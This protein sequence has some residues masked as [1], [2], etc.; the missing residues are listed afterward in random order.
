[1]PCLFCSDRTHTLRFCDS[2]IGKSIFEDV[3]LFILQNKYN[4][5]SQI[6]YFRAFTKPQL[7]FINREINEP[8]S[9][10]KYALIYNIIRHFFRIATQHSEFRNITQQDMN[11]IHS[12]YTDHHYQTTQVQSPVPP[13]IMF[14]I[15]IKSMID[16]FYGSRYGLRRH[17]MSLIRYFELL[18]EVADNEPFRLSFY[19]RE[20]RDQQEVA[21]I[22]D[23]VAN[24]DQGFIDRISEQGINM[25]AAMYQ[26]PN[27]H[28]QKLAFQIDTDA[29]LNEVKDCFLC[30]EEKSHAKLGCSHEYCIDCI[31]GIAKARTKSFISCAVCR[32]EVDLV[33]VGSEAIKA[34]LKQKINTV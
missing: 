34:D 6:I 4:I 8:I 19:E 9:S 15:N 24:L 31:F 1:M 5:A 2:E 22:E 7:A 14:S 25:I 33:Q 32:A 23:M 30:C 3:E 28:L 20:L 11:L 18:D 26:M 12:V 13:S 16:A 21:R 27:R 10:P 17:G 29:S